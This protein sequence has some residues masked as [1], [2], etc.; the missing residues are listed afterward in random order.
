MIGR[1]GTEEE[2]PDW[3]RAGVVLTC[4]QSQSSSEVMGVSH[5][6]SRVWEGL[7]NSRIGSGSTWGPREPPHPP[8]P[9][10]TLHRTQQLTF[11]RD[12]I[13]RM[14]M[15]HVL[16]VMMILLGQM[17]LCKSLSSA[18]AAGSSLLPHRFSPNYSVISHQIS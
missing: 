7:R 11:V 4:R 1:S 16:S 17:E 2:G 18:Q 15:L 6:S 3:G 12:K 10:V 14:H 9:H 5:H 13:K 8:N